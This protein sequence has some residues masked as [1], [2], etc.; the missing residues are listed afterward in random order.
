VLG[1]GKPVL[2]IAED[3]EGE[4]LATLVINVLRGVFKAAAVKA[5]GYGD[6]RKA[7]LEDIAIL[8]GGQ[9]IFEDLGIQLEN[10]QLNQLGKAKKIKIDKDNTT[11][12]EGAGK[13]PNIKARIQTIQRELEKSTSDYDK[14]KLSE[15][16]A[17]LSGGVAKINV[18][19]ATESEMKE[20]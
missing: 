14:E 12:I 9:A 1:Q 20:K 18:G 8:T 19:A 6:R 10:I 13:S 2:I 5:P 17:K 11:I 7:M 15:R 3:V 16:I 4:A